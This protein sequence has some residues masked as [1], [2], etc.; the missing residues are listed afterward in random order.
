MTGTLLLDGTLSG[1][2]FTLANLYGT[3]EIP[4]ITAGTDVRVFSP[5]GT[6]FGLGSD[7]TWNLVP[8]PSALALIGLAASLIVTRRARRG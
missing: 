1:N 3:S 8:K 5:N 6:S 7:F 4:V 2:R